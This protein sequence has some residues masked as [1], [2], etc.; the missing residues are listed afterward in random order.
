MAGIS[1]HYDCAVAVRTK[2]RTKTFPGLPSVQAIDIRA[3]PTG[4]ER[5]EQ[6]PFIA[7]AFWGAEEEVGTL[8]NTDDILLPVAVVLIAASNRDYQANL[9]RYTGWRQTFYDAFRNQRLPDV[10]SILTCQSEPDLVIDKDAF[11]SLYFYSGVL[12]R[13]LDR[14]TRG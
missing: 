9:E 5:L 12:H 6:L 11:S 13:F 1:T 14:R 2:L 8:V 10:S 3:L 4:Q 7:I